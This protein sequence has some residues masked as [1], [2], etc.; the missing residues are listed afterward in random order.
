[1]SA[2]SFDR[3]VDPFHFVAALAGAPR[4]SAGIVRSAEIVLARRGVAH[5]R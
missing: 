3:M 1:M 5:C 4:R 2:F